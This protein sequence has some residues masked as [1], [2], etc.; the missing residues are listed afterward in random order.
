MSR[1]NSVPRRLLA[2]FGVTGGLLLGFAGC[3]GQGS[4]TDEAV[5]LP[6]EP[7]V[8]TASTTTTPGAASPAPASTS[9]AP[10]P[11]DTAPAAGGTGGFGIL[12]GR[13]V[14]NGTPPEAPLLDT[15]AKDPEVCAKTP[16][17]SQRLVVDPETKGV[18]YALV[19]IPKP[20]SVSPEAKSAAEGATVDFDQKGC[21]F[22]PHV[23]A[24][25]KGA[26]VTLKSSDPVNHNINA[27]LRTNAP[28]NSL[29]TPNQ[30]V[31]FDPPAA[32]K[33]PVEVTCDIHPWMK[34]FW[35][36]LDN[37]YFAVTDDK[38]NFEIKNVPAGSQKVV[39]WEEAV[40]YVTPASGT[41]V[42]VKANETTTA[43]DFSIDPSK[44]K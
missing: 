28:Y 31:S 13:V 19:Y 42:A 33:G 32:E 1:M 20:T 34:A 3:G 35:L 21:M 39:V 11:A 4:K 18:K 17:K 10:A 43:P 5:V 8:E 27:K 37:P 12:K 44:V 25:M 14:F 15:K 16:V 38:G 26:K 40:T 36:I 30:A 23:L 9:N 24:F 7:R 41:A 22:D 2:C 29:L 6:S